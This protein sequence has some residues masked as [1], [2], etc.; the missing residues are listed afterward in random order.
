MNG[1]P[2]GMRLLSAAVRHSASAELN[3]LSRKV[4]E[5]LKAR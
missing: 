4:I 1:H 2:K 5:Y 3:E